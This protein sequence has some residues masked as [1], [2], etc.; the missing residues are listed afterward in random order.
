MVSFVY[1][2]AVHLQSYENDF[3]AFLVNKDHFGCTVFYD[4]YQC[5][6]YFIKALS[7]CSVSTAYIIAVST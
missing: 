5:L 2:D 3:S 7:S 1:T 4:S 6:C